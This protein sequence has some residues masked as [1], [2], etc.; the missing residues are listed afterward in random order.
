M[1]TQR[2]LLIDVKRHELNGDGLVLY[3]DQISDEKDSCVSLVVQHA[4]K[5]NDTKDANVK[6]Y[7]YYQP[8]HSKSV[9][10]SLPNGIRYM[11]VI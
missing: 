2:E 5:V 8:E 4:F 7:D 1:E 6:I 11:L 10:Y 3:F 9:S